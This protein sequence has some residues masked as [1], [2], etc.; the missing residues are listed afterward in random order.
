MWSNLWLILCYLYKSTATYNL[1]SAP[2][3][4]AERQ[5]QWTHKD[6]DMDITTYFNAVRQSNCNMFNC[7]QWRANHCTSK[8]FQQETQKILLQIRHRYT[9]ST[10]HK[11]TTNSISSAAVNERETLA[12]YIFT[13][14]PVPCN[15]CWQQYS[16]YKLSSPLLVLLT[17]NS[18]KQMWLWPPI[19]SAIHH[20]ALPCNSSTINK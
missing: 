2:S 11:R 12:L 20:L 15:K 16:N 3:E 6:N 8:W 17:Q 4:L 13:E 18:Y 14:W 5:K 10:N 19:P 9:S 7:K 1:K